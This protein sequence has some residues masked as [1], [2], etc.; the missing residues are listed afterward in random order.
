MSSTS[1]GLRV[2]YLLAEP[3][4]VAR[5]RDAQPLWAVSTLGLVALETCL[6]RGPVRAAEQEAGRVAAERV[7]LEEA[8]TALGVEVAP[9]S[10]APYLLCRVTGRPDVRERLREQGVA[11]RRGDTFPGLTPEH[12]RT[13]VRS[14]D[15]TDRLVAALRAV[16]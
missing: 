2:G 5:L 7:R 10:Q 16:L 11:V 4:T 8:L 12:W 14:D 3:A 13:A 9:G 15:A 1:S 6:A